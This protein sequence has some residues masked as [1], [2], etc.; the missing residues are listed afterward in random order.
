M[1]KR[2]AS[3]LSSEKC[4]Y[5]K[6]FHFSTEATD[7]DSTTALKATVEDDLDSALD[8]ILGMAFEEA[9]DVAPKSTIKVQ[10]AAPTEEDADDEEVAD[11]EVR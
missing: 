9:G 6:A 11:D 2:T 4:V 8:D 1:N 10:A 5:P 7:D 3:L